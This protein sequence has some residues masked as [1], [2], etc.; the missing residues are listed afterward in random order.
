MKVNKDGLSCSSTVLLPSWLCLR[1]IRQVGCLVCWMKL[2]AGM[3]CIYRCESWGWSSEWYS[4]QWVHFS[5]LM[6]QFPSMKTPSLPL[7]PPN[8][9][10]IPFNSQALDHSWYSGKW[11]TQQSNKFNFP[12]TPSFHHSLWKIWK[13]MMIRRI[14]MMVRRMRVMRR[15][16]GE[17]NLGEKRDVKWGIKISWV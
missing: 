12:I 7:L 13:I 15:R 5:T 4:I 3:R 8:I 9:I 16:E 14:L 6:S 1:K 10:K 17:G 2:R 11:R